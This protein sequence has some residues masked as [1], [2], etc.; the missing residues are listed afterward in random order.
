MS[1]SEPFGHLRRLIDQFRSKSI[2]LQIRYITALTI[3]LF[4]GV[5]FLISRLIWNIVYHTEDEY[6][7]VTTERLQGQM[8]LLIDKMEHFCLVFC[9]D[10]SASRI[11]TSDFE[12]T[13][14]KIHAIEEIT[15]Y[16]KMLDPMIEDVAL[17]GDNDYYSTVY[18]KEELIRLR[19]EMQGRDF[20]FLG[21]FEHGFIQQKNRPDMLVFAENVLFDEDNIG[22]V[23]LSLSSLSLNLG[24]EEKKGTFYAAVDT[25]GILHCFGGEEADVEAGLTL[26]REKGCPDT[27]YTGEYFIHAGSSAKGNYT[28]LS[29]LNIR[30]VPVSG[31]LRRVQLLTWFCVVLALLTCGLF[32]LLLTA[33]MIN[34]LARFDRYIRRIRE[35]SRPRLA[36][37]DDL[38]GCAE[39]VQIGNEFRLM[40]GAI[41]QLNRR[42]FRQAS[43][44]YEM[45]IAR[46]TAELASLKSQINPHFLYNTLEVI[47][48]MAMERNAPEIVQMTADMA[49]IFRYSAKGADEVRLEEALSMTSA[50]L[51]IQET[52]FAGKIEFFCFIPEELYDLRVQ[53]MLLQ[54]IVENAVFH[55]LEPKTLK[56][57]LYI[58][59]QKEEDK[60]IL[61]VK[62]DGVGIEEEKLRELQEQLRQPAGDTS[63]H[64]GLLNTNARIRLAYGEEYG[65]RL[66]SRKEDGTTVQMVLPVVQ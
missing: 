49:V 32:L 63:G 65:I 46:Q 60:L 54:P 6:V 45:K 5:A 11:M 43:D 15:A 2:R 42:I 13:S 36:D 52:R 33:D 25:S 19:E 55:G 35:E 58:G 64:V 51:R 29:G 48:K 41:D 1:I 28:M 26:W 21:F 34:P 38:K 37:Q 3:V 14:D 23:I 4:I 31:K 7:S 56:G 16:Y 18:S 44:L 27:V 53:K 57:S 17:V 10:P 66:E 12:K 30:S 62:D 59:A 40:L 47:R 9:D 24:E 39:I 22:T 20:A 8:D 50:Y 61:T